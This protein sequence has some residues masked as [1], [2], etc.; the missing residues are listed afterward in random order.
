MECPPA[1]PFPEPTNL[2]TRDPGNERDLVCWFSGSGVGGE[3][4]SLT[5]AR[6]ATASCRPSPPPPRAAAP[7][8]SPRAPVREAAPAAAASSR[9]PGRP[10]PAGR[11]RPP[12]QAV[13]V[14]AQRPA[15]QPRARPR[16]VVAN[17]QRHQPR[18]PLP[19]PEGEARG[20]V[21]LVTPLPASSREKTSFPVDLPSQTA[22]SALY[23][24]TPETGAAPMAS[25]PLMTL[26]RKDCA[27]L[28]SPSS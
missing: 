22:H 21:S 8:R 10:P 3:V 7:P 27:S 11:R 24:S 15:V 12:R 6:T 4:E 9:P 23:N 1:S 13:H 20:H 14:F 2:R 5:A 19:E 26:S 17:R 18:L 28:F 16:Q 25:A